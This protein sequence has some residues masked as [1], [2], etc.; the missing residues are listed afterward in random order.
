M[1]KRLRFSEEERQPE[2]PTKKRKRRRQAQ[3][4]AEA[5]NTRPPPQSIGNAAESQAPQHQPQ[6]AVSAEAPTPS[7]SQKRSTGRVEKLEQRSERYGVKL[8]SARDAL[9]TKK[10]LIRK[11]VY[12]EQKNKGKSRLKFEEQTVPIGEAKWNKPKKRH[13]PQSIENRT[14]AAV[15]NEIHAEIYAVEHENVGVKAAHRAELLGESAYRGGKRFAR[16]AYRFHKNRPHRKASK[17]EVKS[18]KTEAKLSYQKALRDNPK[19]KSNP[20]S[21]ASQKLAIKRKHAAALRNAKKSGKIAR[22]SIGITGRASRLA[23]G[24]IRRNPVVLLKLAALGLIII[25]LMSMFTMCMSM[26]SG[27][28]V[29]VGAVA[30]AADYEDIDDA[31]ILYTELETDL[32][33]YLR[34]IESTHGSFD[35]YRYD[36]GEINHNPFELMAFLTAVYGEFI[37]AQ[38]EPT[39]HALFAEQYRLGCVV[40]KFMLYLE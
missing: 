8:E 25:L 18:V 12:N 6:S 34:N 16:S 5:E 27:G 33:I 35:E 9:P 7:H 39:L 28:S 17:L 3:Y 19:L 22:K 13:T 36:V 1:S 21:R 11:R 15:A 32:L 23:T 38:V 2:V 29:F 24:I 4:A 30:Y 31:S 20:V 10:K 40:N 26:F 14:K 37:F